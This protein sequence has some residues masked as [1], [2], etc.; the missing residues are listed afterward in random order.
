MKFMKKLAHQNWFS[1]YVIFRVR[2]YY[3]YLY[4]CVYACVY[5][6]IIFRIEKQGRD[7]LTA[8]ST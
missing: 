5:I 7:I 4:K 3:M 8:D 2:R 1:I 6:Y